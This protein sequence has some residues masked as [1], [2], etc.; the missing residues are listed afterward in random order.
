MVRIPVFHTGDGG[1]TPPGS[2]RHKGV[3][4]KLVSLPGCN[5]GA[6]AHC[7]FESYH[8][9]QIRGSSRVIR[10]DVASVEARV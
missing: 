6:V 10:R 4:G 8:T 1:S 7:R 9:H 2:T 3:M 5:P